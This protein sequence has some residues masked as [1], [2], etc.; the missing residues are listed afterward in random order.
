M[1]INYIKDLG[2]GNFS[3]NV[4]FSDGSGSTTNF[5]SSMAEDDQWLE[6]MKSKERI[7]I[8]KKTID[9]VKSLKEKY[10]GKIIKV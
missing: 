10:E 4:T 3:V 9:K 7:V 2:A 6:V 5:N 8:E 1:K